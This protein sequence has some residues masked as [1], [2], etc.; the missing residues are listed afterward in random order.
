MCFFIRGQSFGATR[1]ERNPLGSLGHGAEPNLAVVGV[2]GQA[3][4][5]LVHT[6]SQTS[7]GSG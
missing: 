4:I 1:C 6:T 2:V 5:H 7:Q 3:T